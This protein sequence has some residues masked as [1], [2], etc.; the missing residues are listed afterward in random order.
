MKESPSLSDYNDDV[1]ETMN[2]NNMRLRTAVFM[3]IIGINLATVDPL[4]NY[5]HKIEISSDVNI[6]QPKKEANPAKYSQNFPWDIKVLLKRLETLNL[7][8]RIESI[9][10]NDQNRINSKLTLNNGKNSY[11]NIPPIH[12]TKS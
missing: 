6:K 7:K 5:L 8:M 10:R 1:E 4:N 9:C 12:Y 2:L 11:K 3:L